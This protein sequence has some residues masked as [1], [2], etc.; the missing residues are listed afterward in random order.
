ETGSM[1]K[2]S[3]NH[4]HDHKE[5]WYIRLYLNTVIGKPWIF[6]VLAVAFAA[7]FT[8][9]IKDFTLNASSDAIV[10]ENDKDLRYYDYTREVFG[11]DDYIIVTVTPREGTLV[12]DENIARLAEMSA[13]FEAMPSVQSVTSILNVPLFHSPDVPL[14]LLANG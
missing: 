13:E 2:D 12:S 9:Y 4:V 6:V 5:P 1:S 10:L 7:F 11:S 8:Y 14:M 3:E